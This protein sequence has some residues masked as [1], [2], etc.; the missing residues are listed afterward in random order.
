MAR[1]RRRI[2]SDKSQE[3]LIAF[4]FGALLLT[5]LLVLK[6]IELLNKSRD[7]LYGLTL[8]EWAVVFL[9][10][11]LTV[12]GLMKYRGI[13][14]RRQ[15]EA[16]RSDEL[17]LAV[18]AIDEW[19]HLDSRE[20]L[21]EL[22]PYVFEQ[23]VAQLFVLM[24]YRNEATDPVED[25]GKDILLRKGSVQYLVECN[26]GDGT[27][28]GLMDVEDL[29]SRLAELGLKQGFYVTAGHFSAQAMDYVRNKPITLVDGA[30]LYK[31]IQMY[32]SDI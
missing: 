15:E 31:W 20:R 28:I 5:C 19:R 6:I 13:I 27:E 29:S 22:D 14:K 8:L 18:R 11:L 12:Y 9:F 7:F 21:M 30:T 17:Q 4:L 23:Y 2:Y 26:L 1:G 3:V 16:E 25:G 24:G 32:A 10:I